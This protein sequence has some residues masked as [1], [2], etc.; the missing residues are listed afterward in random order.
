MAADGIAYRGVLFAGLMITDAGPKLIEYNCRF[1]DPE[2]QALMMRL[3]NDFLEVLEA[4]VNGRARPGGI[5]MEQRCG[6][7]SGHGR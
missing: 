1:G 3:K 5:E 4:A 2:C 6:S 7:N